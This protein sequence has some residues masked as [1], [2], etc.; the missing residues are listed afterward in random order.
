M[1]LKYY[2][3]L[4]LLLYYCYT[5]IFAVVAYIDQLEKVAVAMH[6]NSTLQVD[7]LDDILLRF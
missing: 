5:I 1:L 2:L 4:I 6:C 7:V 3:L